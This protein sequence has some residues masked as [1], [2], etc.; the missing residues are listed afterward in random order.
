MTQSARFARMRLRLKGG[1]R[2]RCQGAHPG[3]RWT[4]VESTSE[5]RARAT[6]PFRALPSSFLR[7]TKV[8]P[9][10]VLGRSSEVQRLTA[11]VPEG[12][13]GVCGSG[14]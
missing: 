13:L 7:L 3:H 12:L 9:R 8:G 11:H 4:R 6:R 1:M 10:D 2:M 14:Y 5:N